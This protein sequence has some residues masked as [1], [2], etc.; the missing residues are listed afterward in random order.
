M[1]STALLRRRIPS[2]TAHVAVVGQGFVGLS[3]CAT[4]D[5][6]FTVTGVDVDPRRIDDLN[7]GVLSVAGVTGPTL[8]SGPASGRTGNP[9]LPRQWRGGYRLGC[10]EVHARFSS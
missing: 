6:G 1:K 10:G 4:A 3:L 2:R 7:K 9:R 8:E 5:A